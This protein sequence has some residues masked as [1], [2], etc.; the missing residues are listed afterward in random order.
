MQHLLES[1]RRC[2]HCELNRYGVSSICRGRRTQ[3]CLFKAEAVA[4]P[5]LCFLFGVS[6]VMTLR[7]QSEL[8]TASTPA[9]NFHRLKLELLLDA[10]EVRIFTMIIETARHDHGAVTWTC[11]IFAK[12]TPCTALLK[13]LRSRASGS[14][15]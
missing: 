1:L 5:V 14:C 4:R 11:G 10:V 15:L 2:S 8:C 13:I 3:I 7:T 6:T 9:D 12:I